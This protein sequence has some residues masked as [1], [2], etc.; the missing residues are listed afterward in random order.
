VLWHCPERATRASP[1]QDNLH[2]RSPLCAHKPNCNNGLQ[3][4]I[5]LALSLH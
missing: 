2:S 5:G 3:R 1:A 4:G